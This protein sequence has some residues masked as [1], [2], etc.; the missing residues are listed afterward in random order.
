MPDARFAPWISAE[1]CNG[2]IAWEAETPAGK[3]SEEFFDLAIATDYKALLGRD[4]DAGGLQSFV[5]A[6][7]HGA[8]PQDVKACALDVLRHRV[9]VTYEAE[10]EEE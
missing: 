4:A 2:A 7:Q 9:L 5:A 8:T 1:A 6:M 3:T 10:A